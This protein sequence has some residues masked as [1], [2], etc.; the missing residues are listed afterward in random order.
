MCE[1]WPI[2][3]KCINVQR[4]LAKWIATDPL[5]LSATMKHLKMRIKQ[6]RKLR[7]INCLLQ[8]K[9]NTEKE[10]TKSRREW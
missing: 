6:T 10:K 8:K 9:K 3:Y 5:E 1:P 7:K 4:S 2:H